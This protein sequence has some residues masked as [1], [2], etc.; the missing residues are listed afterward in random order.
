M[1]E[2]GINQGTNHHA[3]RLTEDDVR[4]IRKAAVERDRLKAEAKTLSNEE[5]GKKFGV[6]AATISEVI[7]YKTW[8][9]VL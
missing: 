1:A 3:H 6:R 5:L 8:I 7:T 4:I 9:H 2:H